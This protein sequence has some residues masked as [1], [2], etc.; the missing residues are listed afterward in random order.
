M[1]KILS[2]VLSLCLVLSLVPMTV[3]A[4]NGPATTSYGDYYLAYAVFYELDEEGYAVLDSEGYTKSYVVYSQNQ[5]KNEL[6]NAVYDKETNTLTLNNFDGENYAL[7]TNMMGDDFTIEVKGDCSIIRF[8]IWGDNY[9]GG[10]TIK[11]D[12]T[13]TINPNKLDVIPIIHYEEG[14]SSSLNF[15]AGVTVKIYADE[16]IAYVTQTA[17]SD[18]EKAIT[19]ANGQE[20]EV[21]KE[22]YVENY[23]VN[24]EGFCLDD[25]YSSWTGYKVNCASDPDGLYGAIEF[26]SFDDN[27]NFVADAYGITRYV[28]VDKYQAY[29]VDK[30][31]MDEHGDMFGDYKLT[32][33][34]FEASDF[35]LEYDDYENK[36]END[37]RAYGGDLT[38]AKYVDENG[39]EY[40]VYRLWS[41]DK[42]NFKVFDFEPVE[43]FD[44]Y[45][46]FTLN[47]EVNFDELEEYTE[48]R[49]Y[50]GIFSYEILGTEF[51]Y[52]GSNVEDTDEPTDVD[53]EVQGDI[54]GD[55]NLDITDVV[56]S[57]AF[58][59]GNKDLTPEQIAAGD[60]NG[61]NL[62]DIIDVVMM[63]KA[64]VG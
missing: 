4:Q 53:S 60:M 40:A 63:R 16:T 27:D 22:P 20:V 58:I 56:I 39:N 46:C 15:G 17:I 13:L 55:S 61:D 48:S 1:K 29:L 14:A 19:F 31:Y 50:D 59:V 42:Q 2:I 43:G 9:G 18:T 33:D 62:L 30:N 35:S 28:Y 6:E 57:R 5:V 47:N 38:T 32:F 10:L 25:D 8:V 24:L 7:E 49:I 21:K 52:D 34:E 37:F 45:Y 41:D 64:I 23:G 11:G 3:Y 36:V 51:I 54:S 44:D 12:G 26:G